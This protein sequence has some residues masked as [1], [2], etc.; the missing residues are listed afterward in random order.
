MVSDILAVAGGIAAW[1]IFRTKAGFGMFQPSTPSRDDGAFFSFPGSD[2]PCTQAA[3]VL[4]STG[5]SDGSL[6]NCPTFG[7]ANQG[8]MVLSCAARRIAPANGLVSS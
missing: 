6:E 8:G 3:S 2:F 7:S 4:I 1:G 5:L